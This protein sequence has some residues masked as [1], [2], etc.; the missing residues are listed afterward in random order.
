MSNLVQVCFGKLTLKES[1]A[2][3]TGYT[4]SAGDMKLKVGDF[5]L[6]PP[7][8]VMPGKPQIATVVKIGSDFVGSISSL[9]GRHVE[10]D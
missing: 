7:T 6:T 8:W 1:K 2:A 3:K 4:Y 10:L 5:V 9:V